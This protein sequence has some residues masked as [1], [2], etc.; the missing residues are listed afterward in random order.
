MVMVKV[1]SPSK[2]GATVKDRA[3]GRLKLMA[4]L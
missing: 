4:G 1:P 2:T 3:L